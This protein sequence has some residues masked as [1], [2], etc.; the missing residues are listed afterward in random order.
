MRCNDALVFLPLVVSISASGCTKMNDHTVVPPEFNLH[1]VQ[2]VQ[3]YVSVPPSHKVRVGADYR[4][5]SWL[6]L[7]GGGG[8]YCGPDV[9]APADAIMHERPGTTLPITLNRDGGGCRGEFFRDSLLP[10]RGHW[11]FSSLDT[12]EPAKDSVSLYSELTVHYNF[13]A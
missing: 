7:F 9:D 8:E 3:L 1:P 4:I 5:G 11:Q 12:L 6:G 2:R 13:D 10:G